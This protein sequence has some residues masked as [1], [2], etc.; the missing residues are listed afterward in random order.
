MKKNRENTLKKV[1]DDFDLLMLEIDKK[2]AKSAMDRALYCIVSTPKSKLDQIKP[3]PSQSGKTQENLLN[4]SVPLQDTN[5]SDKISLSK[6]PRQIVKGKAPKASKNT[7]NKKQPNNQEKGFKLL[8][9]RK[10]V[11]FDSINKPKENLFANFLTSKISQ[12]SFIQEQLEKN[13]AVKMLSKNMNLPQT[14]SN[15]KFGIMPRDTIDN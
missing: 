10:S 5:K 7:S 15:F 4:L 2:A 6:S 14:L 1:K 12:H 9:E 13:Q 8:M 11:E 3:L